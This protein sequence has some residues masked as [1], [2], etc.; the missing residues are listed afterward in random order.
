MRQLWVVL[1]LG[2]AANAVAADCAAS[3][4]PQASPAATAQPSPSVA[5][6]V[7]P[8]QAATLKVSATKASPTAP[9]AERWRHP[10]LAPLLVCLL[11]MLVMAWRRGRR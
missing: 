2:M 5:Q 9:A 11:A 4:A 1:V 3:P 7:T 10:L 8:P 6:G